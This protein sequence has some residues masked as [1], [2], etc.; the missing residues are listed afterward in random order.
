MR[1][2]DQIDAVVSRSMG[3]A[4]AARRSY[5]DALARQRAASAHDEACRW[6]ARAQLI[7]EAERDGAVMP[8]VLL[9]AES[10]DASP[11]GSARNQSQTIAE[12]D[13]SPMP[14]PS[15]ASEDPPVVRWLTDR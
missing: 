5:R 12:P 6:A 13:P 8:R 9:P 11:H 2:T 4:D 15:A 7:A 3:D 10:A 14:T 1:P